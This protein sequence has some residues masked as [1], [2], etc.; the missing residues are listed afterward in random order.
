[1]IKA[2]IFDVDG[3]LLESA[4][5]KTQAFALLFADY[6]EQVGELVDY[7]NKNAG[8]SRYVKFRYFYE[9]VLGRELPPVE[10]AELGK[11]YSQIVLEQV[12]KAPLVPGTM[13]FLSKNKDRYRF[14]IASGTPEAELQDIITNRGLSHFFQGIYGSPKHKEEIIR[15]ILVKH[16]FQKKETAYVGDAE[17]DYASAESVGVFFVARV[18]PGNHHLQ[19]CRW[20]IN[21]L[22]V[23]DTILENMSSCLR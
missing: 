15:D 21:D 12:L 16:S 8:L 3:V 23:L 18:V 22:T 7:H 9:N 5:I 13:E 1:M 6:P 10:E 2:V 11:K 17:S 19:K 4:E 14:F 20:K